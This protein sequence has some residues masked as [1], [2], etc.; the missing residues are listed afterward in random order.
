[1]KWLT[2]TSGGGEDGSSDVEVVGEEEG[3]DERGQKPLAE[4]KGAGTEECVEAAASSREGADEGKE[5]R[6]AREETV[7]GHAGEEELDGSESA[8][9]G[10][11]RKEGL[12]GGKVVVEPTLPCAGRIDCDDLARGSRWGLDGP[13]YG[14]V[15]EGGRGLGGA[16]RRSR[17]PTGSGR[18]PWEVGCGGAV[19]GRHSLLEG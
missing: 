13:E 16:S 18:E 5:D 8:V 19:E 15:G 9:G 17:E 11:Q 4:R 10:E 1:M 7:V 14:G 6:R 2:E 3:A 12:I